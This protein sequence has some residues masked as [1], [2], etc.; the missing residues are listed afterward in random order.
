MTSGNQQ[1]YSISATIQWCHLLDNFLH[2]LHLTWLWP[3][4]VL[5][6]KQRGQ[7]GATA[8][9]QWTGYCSTRTWV[10]GGTLSNQPRSL[11]SPACPPQT[12]PASL[13]SQITLTAA[14]R[15]AEVHLWVN[16]SVQVHLKSALLSFL[17]IYLLPQVLDFHYHSLLT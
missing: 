6:G 15:G 17:H 11:L 13:S 10:M 1:F 16:D 8:E 4:L 9:N 5:G 14:R 3:I 12:R 2:F 7:L